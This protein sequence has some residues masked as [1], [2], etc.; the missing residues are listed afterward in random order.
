MRQIVSEADL[1]VT[2]D[3]IAPPLRQRQRA[4]GRILIMLAVIVEVCNNTMPD[5]R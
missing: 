2:R 1:N 4:A 5:E 3:S